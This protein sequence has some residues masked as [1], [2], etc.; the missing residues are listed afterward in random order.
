MS[1]QYIFKEKSE[2]MAAGLKNVLFWR[3]K[4]KNLKNRFLCAENRI[5]DLDSICKEIYTFTCRSS[6]GAETPVA[7]IFVKVGNGFKFK[8]SDLIQAFDKMKWNSPISSADLVVEHDGN[9]EELFK[10]TEIRG[11]VDD[12]GW[13]VVYKVDD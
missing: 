4:L 5:M 11:F 1:S 13:E 8:D 7:Y 9:M 3:R 6:C 12:E 2:K 10:I